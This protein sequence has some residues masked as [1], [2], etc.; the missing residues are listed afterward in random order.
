MQQHTIKYI[1]RRARIAL[2]AQYFLMG[3]IFSSLLSRF[4]SLCENYNISFAQLSLVL[5]SMS[6]GSLCIMPFCS[7]LVGRYGSRK[8]TVVGFIYMMLF[9]FLA[10]M[11]NVYVLYVYA[12]IYGIFSSLTD[13]SVNGNS[14]IVENAYKRPI[15]SMF[16]AFF[17]VGALFGSLLSIVFISFHIHV[18]HHFLLISLFSLSIFS[19]IRSFFLKETIS[20]CHYPKVGFS[21][22]FPT[23]NLLI[24]AFIAF[25]GRIVEG[26]IS[27]WST[28]YMNNVVNFPERLAPLGLAIYSAFLSLGRFVCDYVRVHYKDS[29]ILLFCCSFAFIGVFIMIMDTTPFFALSGLFI[30]GV[31]ISCLIPIIYSLAGKQ[32][33]I[34][35]SVGIAM[36]N[37][38]SGSG[39]LFGPFVIGY[40]ADS[41][42]MR[43]SFIYILFL[44]FIMTLLV[45]FFRTREKNHS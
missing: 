4:P 14:I 41:F 37:T 26:S 40:I 45:G 1:K 19:I 13:V 23:G 12:A 10:C 33:G 3:L 28:L 15:I 18:F 9:P 7:Y 6:I 24:I 34:S 8:L 25:F 11:P 20:K 43:T 32:K 5:F 30:S 17:Y 16:H 38:I 22:I 31:G 39:F 21:F 44:A 29:M 42:G 36:V 35:P 2:L 27:D